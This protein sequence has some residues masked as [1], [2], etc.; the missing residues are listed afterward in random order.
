MTKPAYTTP[1]TTPAP[2]TTNTGKAPVVTPPT[3]PVTTPTTPELT[4]VDKVNAETRARVEAERN[5][6]LIQPT[7]TE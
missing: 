2:T 7:A 3:T 1:T 4:G 6:Q 5:A